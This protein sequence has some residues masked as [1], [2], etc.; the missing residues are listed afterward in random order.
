MSTLSSNQH[1]SPRHKRPSP[2]R[3][4]SD[5]A[6]RLTE[7]EDDYAD[8]PRNMSANLTLTRQLDAL[9]IENISFPVPQARRA[10][11]QNGRA[12][13]KRSGDGVAN[14]IGM[15]SP[16]STPP[17]RSPSNSLSSGGSVSSPN[18]KRSDDFRFDLKQGEIVGTG[19]WSTVYR[20]DSA[21][22]FSSPRPTAILTPP[23]TPEKTRLPLSLI[24]I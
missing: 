2:L 10:S 13:V 7:D 18:T 9:D 21:P 4:K 5:Q 20:V 23:S 6:A 24:H 3:I 17:N 16:P 14:D 12:F 11:Q 15:I 1:L 19:L 22:R 8:L